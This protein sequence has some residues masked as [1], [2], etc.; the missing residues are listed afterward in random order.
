MSIF[1]E[2]LYNGVDLAFNGGFFRYYEVHFPDGE[3]VELLIAVMKFDIEQEGVA[4]HCNRF[5][6]CA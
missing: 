5:I 1:R 4:E 3:A 6:L 2:D